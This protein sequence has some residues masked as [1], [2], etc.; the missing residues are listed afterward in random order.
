MTKKNITR[1]DK[2]RWLAENLTNE[3]VAKLLEADA[4]NPMQGVPSN[5][6]M[7]T[8]DNPGAMKP[9]Q[10]R[11]AN[12]QQYTEDQI[13]DY[14]VKALQAGTI[15]NAAD[16]SGVLKII[17]NNP[18]VVMMKAITKA[19]GQ[20]ETNTPGD[21]NIVRGIAALLGV[22]LKQ[23][24][25][26][27][28]SVSSFLKKRGIDTDNLASNIKDNNTT[29]VAKAGKVALSEGI[30]ESVKMLESYVATLKK[31]IPSLASNDKRQALEAI[32]ESVS[33]LKGN[34]VEEK[35]GEFYAM[36]SAIKKVMTMLK[37]NEIHPKKF[38]NAMK[39][40]SDKNK[41]LNEM[42][43]AVKY[44]MAFYKKNKNFVEKE[45]GI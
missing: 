34:D 44:S 11:G 7:E 43:S 27:A 42:M 5:P 19:C 17:G 40:A 36:S 26:I 39:A 4:P 1:E 15:A 37:E 41:S 14:L 28:E 25:S 20:M 45:L 21:K 6:G 33:K 13:V 18:A 16:P 12:G 10:Q 38:E 24:F 9:V 8:V 2:L 29:L 3:Q 35:I 22:M 31:N 30:N 23:K 32:T